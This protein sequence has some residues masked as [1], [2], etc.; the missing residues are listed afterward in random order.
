M[1]KPHSDNNIERKR[2]LG[3]LLFEEGKEFFNNKQIKEALNKFDDAIK[4][5]YE[6][7]KVYELRG[8]CL[9]KLEYYY[10]AVD[11]FN[12]A[13]SWVTNDSNLYFIRSLTKSRIKDF[14]G[15]VEDLEIAIKI[16]KMDSELNKVYDDEAQKQGYPNSTAYYEFRLLFAEQLLRSDIKDIEINENSSQ[17]IKELFQSFRKKIK[18]RSENNYNKEIDGKNILT[19]V[20]WG[21]KK[22][23]S[24]RFKDDM[25]NFIIYE[26]LSFSIA[27]G[28]VME[29]WWALGI[30]IIIS[31]FLNII[32]WHK[33]IY[34]I[35][36]A[37]FFSIGWGI[38][39]F[40]YCKLDN[41]S[42]LNS[43]MLGLIVLP[44]SWAI[45]YFNLDWSEN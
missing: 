16:S 14:K 11:D 25:E 4:F 33:K 31:L 2:M 17:E 40:F 38:I 39:V 3:M 27:I 21:I 43:F 41:Y 36:P 5:G 22:I 30:S 42:L 18:R 35:Y 44:F 9:E 1:K 26:F 8:W 6:N 37:V 15:A 32:V 10:D 12:K 19:K 20:K 7:F 45:H 29:S 13:I 24:A 34:A 28:L 23:N